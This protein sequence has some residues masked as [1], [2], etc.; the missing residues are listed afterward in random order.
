MFAQESLQDRAGKHHARR[1][2]DRPAEVEKGTDRARDA[3]PASERKTPRKEQS[4]TAE[5]D[6]QSSAS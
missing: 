2:F 4:A 5:P 6:W 3:S 1:L